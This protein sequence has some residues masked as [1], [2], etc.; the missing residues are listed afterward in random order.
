MMR[1]YCTI[2]AII[3]LVDFIYAQNNVNEIEFNE[4]G[5]FESR[6]LNVFAFNNYYNGLFGDKI[7]S[8]IEIIH[9]GVRTVTNGDV[10]LDPTPAQWN[11][12]PKYIE[13]KNYRI[14]NISE[15]YLS[16]PEYNFDHIIKA[17]PKNGSI[18]LSVNLNKALPKELVGRA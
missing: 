6:G 14:N 12:I 3:L 10:R 2:L 9:H 17:E 11:L 7:I 13:K 4:A 5:Y 1:I 18:I 15:A 8:G 16:Y